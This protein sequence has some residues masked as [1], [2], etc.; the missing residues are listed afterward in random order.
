[1][2]DLVRA[3][4]AILFVSPEP[5]EL[6]A[7]CEVTESAP[8][9]VQRALGELRARLDAG[10]GLELAEVGSGVTLRTRADLAEV[11]DRMR[12]RPAEQP[13][14]RPALE[15]LAVVAYLEPVTRADIAEL[16]GVAPDATIATLIERDLLEE[17]A[18]RAR[19]EAR[20]YRTT[21]TFRERFGLGSAS[22]LPPIERFALSGP[23]AEEIRSR[24]V[25][26]GA[27]Q[28]GDSDHEPV[29]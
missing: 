16:R 26:A 17:V 20:R 11:C 13:L 2:T 22:P 4:E 1:V 5:V 24:L 15:T 8:G 19:G 6:A 7:I 10:S 21:A 25:A 3:I 27:T 28:L 12:G 18:R 14:S 23:E 9:P 29:G